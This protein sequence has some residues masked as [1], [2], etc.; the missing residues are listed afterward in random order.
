MKID[1]VREIK[2]EATPK[3]LSTLR[4]FVTKNG[5]KMELN[6][7]Q[8]NH[9]KLCIDEAG[10]NI[11]RHAYVDSKVKKKEILVSMLNAS[12]FIETKIIDWGRDFS[13]DVDT[14]TS[15]DLH[16][17]VEIKK[18]GG[19]GLFMIKKFMDEVDYKREENKNVLIMRQFVERPESAWNLF[20]KNLTWEQVSLKLKFSLISAV[21]ISVLLFSIFFIS[22]AY[23]RSSLEKQY[24]SNAKKNIKKLAANAVPYLLDYND[25]KLTLLIK[26]LKEKDISIKYAGLIDSENYIIAHTD[27]RLIYKKYK[28]LKITDKKV[29]PGITTG[30]IKDNKK[31][32]YFNSPIMYKNLK[33][34]EVFIVL[35]E[36]MLQKEISTF[37]SKLRLSFITIFLWILGVIGTYFLGT[38]FIHPLKQL[39][40][41]IKRVSKE[42]MGGRL[43]FKGK[44]EFA[45]VAKAFNRMMGDLR[46]AEVELTDTTRLKKEMQLAKSIQHTLLPKE[47]PRIEGYDIGAK[48]E[49]AME[50]GG[51]YYDFFNVDDNSIGIAVGDV[52]GKGIAGALIMTMTRTALRLE[53]RGNKNA[54]HVLANLNSTLEGEF[55]KGMYITMFYVVL[56]AKKRIINYSSAGHNPM[57]LYRGDTE[58]LYNFN[59][60]GFAV[61]LDLGS[62]QIFRNA[63]KNESIKLKKGDLLFIYTDGITEAMNSNR[64]EFGEYRLLDMIKQYHHLPAQ[65]MSDKVLEVINE[66]TA[67]YPQ[68]DDI[69]YVVV[70]EKANVSEIEYNKRVKLF[71]L[72]ENENMRIKKACKEVGKTPAQYYRLKAIKDKHGIEALQEDIEE[73][74]RDIERLDIEGGTKLLRLIASH[75]EYSIS[76]LRKELDTEKYGNYKVD[77]KMIS[78]ELKRLNLATIDRRIRFAKRE[79]I[80]AA[81]GK[82]SVFLRSGVTSKPSITHKDEQKVTPYRDYIGD[83]KAGL[84][85]TKIKKDIQ[86]QVY[87]KETH[88]KEDKDLTDKLEKPVETVKIQKEPGPV[89]E[90]KGFVKTEKP[91]TEKEKI[92]DFKIEEIKKKEEIKIKDI[93]IT[94]KEEKKVIKKEKRSPEKVKKIKTDKFKEKLKEEIIFPEQKKIKESIKSPGEKEVLPN[95]DEL[96]SS[97][98]M[99]DDKDF[100]ENNDNKILKKIESKNEDI[101]F[102]QNIVKEK[103]SGIN[104]PDDKVK[105][106]E[107]FNKKAEKKLSNE[108]SNDEKEQVLNGIPSTDYDMDEEENQEELEKVYQELV[109]N[110]NK[111][112]K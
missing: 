29:T 65:E 86:P 103:K 71:E 51:D 49:A 35:S 15:P 4:N 105:V 68:S 45:D 101:I 53:A 91:E 62:P 60:K 28:Q 111:N 81:K 31:L 64:E 92:V 87:K 84:K 89:V 70:K 99:E 110:I 76:S 37:Q 74:K 88:I 6:A 40:D 52:S 78:K 23:Q 107:I 34:G 27:V 59:P 77:T 19:L 80:L 41:E 57:I 50:V 104:M 100:K 36:I 44:G 9:L 47:I 14:L 11:I 5:A 112:N 16:R 72:I 1:A 42:G 21:S 38:I 79:K 95:V 10:S 2:L 58:Q 48:Y 30:K 46:H 97:V 73:G 96:L 66:F 102:K 83:D 12:E 20:K 106:P 69:T 82:K 75:P 26:E 108:L 94:K 93:F 85:S 43:Y 22:I 7:R 39:A 32:R 25:L 18:K 8:L 54:S 56:D 17:Y 98:K 109:V 63:I 33:I 13:V 67:G 90:E 24:F 61:G 55:K 3:N